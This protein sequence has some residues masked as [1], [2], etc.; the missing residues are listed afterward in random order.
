MRAALSPVTD[1]LLARARERARAE[2]VRA[3]EETRDTLTRAEEQASRVIADA[4]A[5]GAAAAE[6]AAAAQRTFGRRAARAMVLA[7]RRRAYE[8]LRAAAVEELI[9]RAAT[10]EGRL[11]TER[12]TAWVHE[13]AGEA[14]T[15]GR[16]EQ[17]TLEAIARSGNGLASLGPTAL[18]DE[19]LASLSDEVEAL[20]S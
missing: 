3:D 7:A 19:A 8:G 12:M 6:R 16:V 13:R 15:P 5:E 20:W 18:I 11:L 10:P 14:A 1:A 17:G 2:L 4:K 9:A